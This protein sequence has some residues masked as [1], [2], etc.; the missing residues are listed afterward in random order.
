MTT[1]F[2]IGDIAEIC[3]PLDA[4]AESGYL[5][6]PVGSTAQVLYVG[7]CDHTEE[8]GWLFGKHGWQH[9]YHKGQFSRKALLMSGCTA[10]NI[11]IRE[12]ATSGRTALVT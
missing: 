1:C 11:H 10:L 2:R 7:A 12:F 8:H 6:V 9:Y 3:Q 4:H 5:Q